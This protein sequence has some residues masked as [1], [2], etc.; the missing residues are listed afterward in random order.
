M[1]DS[2]G[3]ISAMVFK[4]QKP[5]ATQRW[6][7]ADYRVVGRDRRWLPGPRYA[8]CPRICRAQWPFGRARVLHRVDSWNPNPCEAWFRATGWRFF[9][10]AKLLSS[11]IHFSFGPQAIPVAWLRY[12]KFLMIEAAAEER[13]SSNQN[14]M[15]FL[16][17]SKNIP[18]PH[19]LPSGRL[20][21][22]KILGTLAISR[23]ISN[24]SYLSLILYDM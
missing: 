17:K 13:L 15:L 12:T 2:A 8:S 16:W 6:G 5:T 18:I 9:Y 14:L 3:Y 20:H 1:R 24:W 11:Y 4:N 7:Q 22:D 19:S 21:G 10:G 23:N